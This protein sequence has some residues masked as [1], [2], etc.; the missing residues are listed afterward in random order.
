MKNYD[1]NSIIIMLKM[2]DFIKILCKFKNLSFKILRKTLFIMP[3]II[4]L[5]CCFTKKTTSLES[6]IYT[7]YFKD[8]FKK[9]KKCFW[10]TNCFCGSHCYLQF[11]LSEK[12]R[13]I[14]RNRRSSSS[15]NPTNQP[16]LWIREHKHKKIFQDPNLS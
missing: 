10:K 6:W 11:L 4:T 12:H 2:T 9:R 8:N 1:I 3:C 16:P 13:K 7:R 5:Y 15:R 14:V